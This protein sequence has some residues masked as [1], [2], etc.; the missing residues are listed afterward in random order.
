M[1]VMGP[2]R[3]VDRLKPNAFVLDEK[4]RWL[5]ELE[6]NVKNDL[7]E[8]YEDYESVNPEW[9]A[10][11]AFGEEGYTQ[12]QALLSE[13]PELLVPFPYDAIYSTWIEAKIDLANG[14]TGKYNNTMAVFQGQYADF[15]NRCNRTMVHRRGRVRYI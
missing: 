2:I 6:G 11:D 13:P 5:N 4:L 9:Y 14:E 8:R 7:E 10:A 1:N 12:E 3:N 15:M